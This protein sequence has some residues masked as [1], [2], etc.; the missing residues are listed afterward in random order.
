MNVL[1]KIKRLITIGK[2]ERKHEQ[3]MYRKICTDTLTI[4][5]IQFQ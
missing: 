5:K 2:K 4:T 1:G 3:K